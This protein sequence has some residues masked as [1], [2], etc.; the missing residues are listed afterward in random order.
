MVWQILSTFLFSI[1]LIQFLFCLIKIVFINRDTQ[2]A[3][4]QAPLRECGCL[5]FLALEWL[6]LIFYRY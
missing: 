3:I 6:D 2:S 4:E 5:F 1:Q